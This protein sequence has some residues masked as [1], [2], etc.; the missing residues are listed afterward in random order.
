MT[1]KAKKRGRPRMKPGQAKRA[2]FNTRLRAPLKEHLAKEAAIAGRSLSEE[3]EH[4]LERS[5]DVM[6]HIEDAFGSEENYR[7]ARMFGA[8][9]ARQ[10]ATEKTLI[11]NDYVA[12]TTAVINWLLSVRV[13]Y[14]KEHP[15]SLLELMETFG[16]SSFVAP[17]QLD[18][19][20]RSMSGL[21]LDA[22]IDE[23]SQTTDRKK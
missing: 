4:R 20:A 6:A 12:L 5:L 9:A 7:L 14:E 11:A 19:V 8:V 13:F 23:T 3:I 17:V 18:D 1:A 10:D 15:A 16:A 2:S 22:P 21:R